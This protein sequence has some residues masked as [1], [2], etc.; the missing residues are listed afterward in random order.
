MP[1]AQQRGTGISPLE[2][3]M[4][5]RVK[6]RERAAGGRIWGFGI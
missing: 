1:S 5:E 4:W 3:M 2:I 6:K